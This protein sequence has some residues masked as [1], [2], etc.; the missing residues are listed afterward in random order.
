M[1]QKL[2]IPFKR[3]MMLCGYKNANYKDAWGYPHYGV[4]ISS[5]QGNAGTDDNIYGSGVG[6]VVAAGKDNSLGYGV[7]VLYKDC[8]SRDGTE[9]VDLIV[10][11]MHMVSIAVAKGDT[12]TTD[13]VL[14][15][16]GKEGTE[17]YHL[18]MELDTDTQYPVYTPQVSK[19]HT[20]WKKGTDSTLNP[21]LWMWQDENHVLVTPTYNPAWLNS[22]D[23]DVPTIVKVTGQ[24]P[25]AYDEDKCEDYFGNPAWYV[26]DKE[27]GGYRLFD[28][29]WRRISTETFPSAGSYA[30]ESEKKQAKVWTST[31]KEVYADPND[32]E[33]KAGITEATDTDSEITTLRAAVTAYEVERAT[34]LNRLKEIITLLEN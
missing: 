28:K 4:D 15:V 11:Y 10:R 23:K 18:H 9:T 32:V 30:T 1:S 17:D 31:I 25:I 2:I 24:I 27:I 14:G 13:T 26:Y 12:V 8:E 20:F 7:A 3:A 19:G 16:E 6:E 21:S 22:E 33:G 34:I 5:K 29:W